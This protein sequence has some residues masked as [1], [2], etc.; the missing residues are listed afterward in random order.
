MFNFISRY[1]MII[2]EDSYGKSYSN[3]M[4]GTEKHAQITVSGG[5]KGG[6][7]WTLACHTSLQTVYWPALGLL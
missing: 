5:V 6:P 2:I 3:A 4:H 1:M 7:G